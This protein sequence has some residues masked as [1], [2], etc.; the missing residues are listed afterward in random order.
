METLY[1]GT[2]FAIVMGLFVFA[3]GIWSNRDEKQHTH[4]PAHN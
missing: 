3:L 4:T 2:I 1:L